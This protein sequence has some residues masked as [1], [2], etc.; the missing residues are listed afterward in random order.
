[1]RGSV[2]M[3]KQHGDFDERRYR[4]TVRFESWEP[5]SR[6][7]AQ[8]LAARTGMSSPILDVGFR[9]DGD[10]RATLRV[11]VQALDVE[12]TSAGSIYI[13][14]LAVIE[15]EEREVTILIPPD[16]SGL[17]LITIAH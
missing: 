17:A 14:R 12:Q 9:H 10:E 3:D 7:E 4:R 5:A 6:V 15:G 2:V 11:D 16:T 13:C 8:L 1:M